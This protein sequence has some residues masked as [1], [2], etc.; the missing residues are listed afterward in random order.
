M[1][2]PIAAVHHPLSWTGRITSGSDAVR[3]TERKS[4]KKF[5][6]GDLNPRCPFGLRPLRLIDEFG[7][8]DPFL[9]STGWGRDFTG[10]F[11]FP[12]ND[13]LFLG[14]ARKV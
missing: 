11:R 3:T 8:V 1:N 10:D 7:I 13:C 14:P 5:I 9:G 12:V 4:R 6:A 2:M